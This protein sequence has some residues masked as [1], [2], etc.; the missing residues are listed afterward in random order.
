MKPNILLLALCLLALRSM[1]QETIDSTTVPDT[2]Y[3]RG[4]KTT[5]TKQRKLVVGGDTVV[6]RNRIVL[7]ND[8]HGRLRER[9]DSL[10]NTRNRAK[11]IEHYLYD[12]AGHVLSIIQISVNGKGKYEYMKEFRYN[13]EGMTFG[14]AEYKDGTTRDFDPATGK[15]ETG[16]RPGFTKVAD[17]SAAPSPEMPVEE[18]APERVGMVP[19]GSIGVGPAFMHF[20]DKDAHYDSYG[21]T[22]SFTY[23]LT[24]NVGL[25]ADIGIYLHQK[26]W[27]LE[28]QNYTQH[29]DQYNFTAGVSYMPIMTGNFDV[30][31]HALAG[32]SI[33]TVKDETAGYGSQHSSTSSLTLNGGAGFQYF[34]NQQLGAGLEAAYTPSFFYHTTQNN[35][36]LAA[37]F[38]YR[39]FKKRLRQ[40]IQ[41]TMKDQAGMNPPVMLAMIKGRP[42]VKQPPLTDPETPTKKVAD[43]VQTKSE[44][45][46]GEDLFRYENKAKRPV[47]ATLIVTSLC[48]CGVHV[49]AWLIQKRAGR[50]PKDEGSG[51]TKEKKSKREPGT[52][53]EEG[54]RRLFNYDVEKLE[55]SDIYSFYVSAESTIEM[56]IFCARGKAP[57]SFNRQF[58]VTEADGVQVKKLDDAPRLNLTDSTN[59]RQQ[60]K[61]TNMGNHC[62]S[63]DAVFYKIY[64]RNVQDVMRVHYKA[65]SECDC[66]FEGYT[67]TDNKIS[68]NPDDQ[69]AHGG[70]NIG[71]DD[72]N[73]GVPPG[74]ATPAPPNGYNAAKEEL[75]QDVPPQTTLYLKGR[76]PYQNQRGGPCKGK[77][78]ITGIT[79]TNH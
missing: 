67:A 44:K 23:N 62:A 77:L 7:Y 65:V 34:F 15:M 8:A 64:N 3:G 54:A 22:G 63:K 38:F 19:A 49:F 11:D 72:A 2:K 58:S 57:C 14:H 29:F 16:T 12:S 35:Y 20:G 10:L 73:Y 45:C 47:V 32:L 43:Y 55:G 40:A 59:S 56:E 68:D 79:Y 75:V 25:K 76:C 53:P 66:Y 1:S 21:G 4:T 17:S 37:L 50:P 27:H 30:Y 33:Y 69:Y 18:K 71:V 36:R 61:A 46:D 52:P 28:N 6:L 26:T 31:L 24:P 78:V 41:N 74:M 60:P 13:S 42:F 5:L 39:L 48:D 51:D 9:H 70:K